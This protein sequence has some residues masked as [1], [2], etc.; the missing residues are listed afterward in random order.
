MIL[1]LSNINLSNINHTK[2]KIILD[3]EEQIMWNKIFFNIIKLKS[4]A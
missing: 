4:L 2:Q 1:H 3:S